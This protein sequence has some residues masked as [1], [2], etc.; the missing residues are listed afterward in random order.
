MTHVTPFILQAG[1][2]VQGS[3]LGYHAY[4]LRVDNISNQWLQEESTLV[5]IPPY[6]LGVVVRLWGTSVALLIP[7]A[8]IGQPQL[9]PITGEYAVAV[10][11]DEFRTENPGVPVRQFTLVQSVSDLS[12]GPQPALPP[13]GVDRLYADATGNI[14][15]LHSDGTDL[16]LVDPSNA[17]TLLYPTFDPHYQALVN[18][19][20]LGGDLSGTIANG[21][22]NVAY[23]GQIS[24]RDSGGTTRPAF[25]P[26]WTGGATVFW[27]TGG[28]SYVW[29][30]QAGGTLATM[31]TAGSFQ[32]QGAIAAGGPV[33]GSIGDLASRRA[34]NQGYVWLGGDA[35]H[36]LGFNG[37]TYL[38]VNSGLQV[39]GG[40]TALGDS[41]VQRSGANP[42]TDG[43]LYFGNSG[44]VYLFYYTAGLYWQF[45]GGNQ[46]YMPGIN[47]SGSV[48]LPA[49]SIQRAALANNAATQGWILTIAPAG[50]TTSTTPVPM[51]SQLGT[52]LQLTGYTGGRLQITINVQFMHSLAASACT[53]NLYIN[54]VDQNV[55]S[56]TR[57]AVA[58]GPDQCVLT[59]QVGAGVIA[60]GNPLIQVYWN[61]D[62]G[63]LTSNTGI[64]SQVICN[65]FIK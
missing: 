33:I 36:Y 38:L 7:S 54:G 61:T 52:G 55:R 49:G 46:V 8:P 21:H 27:Q 13:V 18:A 45:V 31:D 9:A 30:N 5:W 48:T 60:A 1:R 15:H 12:E 2:G 35:Q 29:A 26:V 6:S 64:Y 32:A 25:A 59:Y 16:T 62:T 53:L 24:G 39:G 4:S 56:S 19:T 42:P 11:S 37:S 17:G 14:H 47:V 34:S 23:L 10:Y 57:S 51:P 22:V 20:A 3:S 44:G 63:T 50:N 41:W 40:V 58:N 65:E 43:L 28:V